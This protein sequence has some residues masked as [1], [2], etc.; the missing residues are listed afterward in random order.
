MTAG[1]QLLRTLEGHTQG[2]SA[3]CM[4]PDGLLLY[5]A[6]DDKLVRQLSVTTGEV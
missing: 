5:T 6:S 4:S 2:V 3:L 1:V